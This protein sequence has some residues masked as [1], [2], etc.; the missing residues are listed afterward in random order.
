[1]KEE[2]T[3]EENASTTSEYVETTSVDD[4]ETTISSSVDWIPDNSSLSNPELT[5]HDMADIEEHMYDLMEEYMETEMIHISSANFFKKF[6]SDIT[7]VCYQYWLECEICD[8][9]DYD[10]IEEIVGEL[11]NIYFDICDLRLQNIQDIAN[12]TPEAK[13]VFITEQLKYLKSIPQAKQKTIEWYKTR[14]NLITASNC[15]KAFGSESQKNALIYDKCKPFSTTSYNYVNTQSTL[16]WGVKYEPVSLMVY[17]D[18]YHTKIEDFGCIPHSEYPFVGASPDGINIDTTNAELYGRMVEIKNIFNREITGIPKEEYW[19]QTQIQME[20]CNLDEC[21]L[22]ETR[23]KEYEN[24]EAYYMNTTHEYKGIILHFVHRTVNNSLQENVSLNELN[25]PIYKYMP[26]SISQSNNKT[27][28]DEWV[29]QTKEQNSDII[30]FNKIYWY[31]DQYSC[32]L[33]KRNKQ[34]FQTAIPKI[35]E[36]WDIIL[37]ERVDGYEHRAAKKKIKTEIIVEKQFENTFTNT[38]S[39]IIKNLPQSVQTTIVKLS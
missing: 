26:L 11:S 20:T 12:I 17:E 13:N 39:H 18:K 38:S 3:S 36:I 1:M 2:T 6:V 31:I 25:T 5:I 21:D 19:I 8:E 37:K 7:T 34:W 32:T 29:R 30:L 14:Y 24:E 16:H 9:D 35:K 23:I 10:E 27:E 4:S 15:W 22:F 28:I 33:I